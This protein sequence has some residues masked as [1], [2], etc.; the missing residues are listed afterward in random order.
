MS[1]SL[2]CDSD[3]ISAGDSVKVRRSLAASTISSRRTPTPT[4]A[5][6]ST[7]RKAMGRPTP[8][9]LRLTFHCRAGNAALGAAGLAPL[10]LSAACAARSASRSWRAIA[11][12]LAAAL[13]AL[14]V[15]ALAS[16]VGAEI[17]PAV[18]S[19][20][21][22][23][24]ARV[25]EVDFTVFFLLARTWWMGRVGSMPGRCHLY[26]KVYRGGSARRLRKT[27]VCNCWADSVAA[28][29]QQIREEWLPGFMVRKNGARLLHCSGLVTWCCMSMASEQQ[30][31]HAVVLAKT[32]PLP[33]VEGGHRGRRPQ[34]AR[35]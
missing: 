13:R 33:P 16:G 8:S 19:A 9:S 35:R 20:I 30:E 26:D 3:G 17:S 24:S 23:G 31:A 2:R 34:A 1:I 4:L 32:H 11:F 14:L 25:A 28:S 22:R 6:L 21:K 7:P 10:V 29:Q 27:V 15:W 5:S 12:S 18:I